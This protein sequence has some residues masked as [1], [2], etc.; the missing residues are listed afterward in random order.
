[1]KAPEPARPARHPI[2]RSHLAV[3]LAPELRRCLARLARGRTIVI[4]F[5][6]VSCCR[7]DILLGDLGGHFAERPDPDLVALAPIEGVPV[8]VDPRLVGLLRTAG[9]TIVL[10]GPPFARHLGIRLDDP[11]AWLEFLDSPAARS[12]RSADRA[13][14]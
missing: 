9:P 11:A 12:A 4:D 13:G 1:M 10:A 14:A 3:G 6:A 8:A 5:V 7:R 2:A